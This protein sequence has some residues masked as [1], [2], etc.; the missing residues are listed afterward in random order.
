MCEHLAAPAVANRNRCCVQIWEQSTRVREIFEERVRSR[1]RSTPFLIV[2]RRISCGRD[3]PKILARDARHARQGFRCACG[4]KP[5][6]VYR[7]GIGTPNRKHAGISDRPPRRCRPVVK[8]IFYGAF[9][10]VCPSFKMTR[11]DQRDQKTGR[12]SVWLYT[13]ATV[14]APS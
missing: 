1:V 13:V 8:L 6:G 3:G 14:A 7:T 12:G 10:M 9:P 5:D 11:A 2:P 4:W